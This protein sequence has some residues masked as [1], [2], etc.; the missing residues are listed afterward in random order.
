MLAEPV[1]QNSKQITTLN[2]LPDAHKLLFL[3]EERGRRGRGKEGE[4]GGQR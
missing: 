1:K 4:G 2:Y 3:G